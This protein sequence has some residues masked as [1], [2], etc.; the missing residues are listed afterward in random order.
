M[1]EEKNLDRSMGESEL[2]DNA[3]GCLLCFRKGSRLSCDYL[4]AEFFQNRRI[5]MY[6]T[7]VNH[8]Q[9]VK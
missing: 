2:E 8:P 9:T 5:C 4:L 3:G 7:K 6:G 1:K